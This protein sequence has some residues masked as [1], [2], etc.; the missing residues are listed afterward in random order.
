MA[1]ILS[2]IPVLY[3]AAYYKNIILG[4]AKIT[5]LGAKITH[6]RNHGYSSPV[7]LHSLEEQKFKLKDKISDDYKLIYKEQKGK[8]GIQ[9]LDNNWT[10]PTDGKL[11]LELLGPTNLIKSLRTVASSVNIFPLY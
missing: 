1:Y 11:H 3:R 10:Q 7:K 8:A 4:P 5:H 2:K 9:P 6:I